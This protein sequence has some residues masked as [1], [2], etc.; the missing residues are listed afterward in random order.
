MKIGGPLADHFGTVGGT[1]GMGP[2]G[3]AQ[4]GMG[5][6]GVPPQGPKMVRQYSADF[7]NSADCTPAEDFFV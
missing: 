2:G 4:G 5:H 1:G 7:P 3:M 6:G